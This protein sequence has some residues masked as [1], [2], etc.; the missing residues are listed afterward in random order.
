MV[1][2]NFGIGVPLVFGKFHAKRKRRSLGVMTNA[3]TERV[4]RFRCSTSVEVKFC[5]C[6]RLKSAPLPNGVVA[7]ASLAQV[8]RKFLSVNFGKLRQLSAVSGFFLS[9]LVRLNQKK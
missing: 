1:D 3:D 2:Y 6:H 5:C 9:Y 7:C 8:V 4:G